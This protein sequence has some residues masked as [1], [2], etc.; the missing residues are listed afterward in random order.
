MRVI[1]I[2]VAAFTVTLAMGPAA[3]VMEMDKKSQRANTDGEALYQVPVAF[4]MSDGTA[5][6]VNVRVAG[7]APTVQVGAPV[8]I[9]GLVG[10][11]W[12]MGGRH[13]ISYSAASVRPAVGSPSKG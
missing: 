13:G 11:V 4:G 2:D 3:P 1:P 12:E 7:A 9:T 5:S 10:R 8:V 6:V